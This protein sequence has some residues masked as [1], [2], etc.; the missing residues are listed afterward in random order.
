MVQA[1]LQSLVSTHDPKTGEVLQK[2]PRVVVSNSLATIDLQL[3]RGICLEPY[4][5]VRALGRI[6]LRKGDETVAVG[7]VLDVLE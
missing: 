2:K 5:K 6:T 7:K 3:E 1:T 4:E